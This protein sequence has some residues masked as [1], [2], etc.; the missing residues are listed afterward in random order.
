MICRGGVNGSGKAGRLRGFDGHLVATVMTRT[1][2]AVLFAVINLLIVTTIRAESPASAVR[3]G[4][5]RWDNWNL[6]SQ[7]P[8]LMDDTLR[9][10]IPYFA[11]RGSDGRLLFIGDIENVLHADIYYAKSAAINYF[12]FG[13]YMDSGAWRRDKSQ[14]QALN[15]AFQSYLNLSDRGGV[16]F[17]LSF[18]WS[19][20][21][22]DVEEVSRI[23]SGVANHPNYENAHSGL[24]PVFFFTPDLEKWY[25]GFG[26]ITGASEALASI[27][28]RVRHVTGKNIYA[29][30]FLFGINR[31]GPTAIELGFDALSTYA[32]GVGAEGKSVPYAA[33]AALARGFWESARKLPAGFLPTVTMGWDYR[34]ALKIPWS[35]PRVSLILAG[36]NLRRMLNGEGKSWRP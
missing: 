10:R 30:A 35:S 14:A 4:A 12:I 13:Y 31:F 20:P 21:N 19:F 1:Y 3:V 5:I 24:I 28:R 34:P 23:I 17:A 11:H 16:N 7:H 9:N 15:R 32:N 6:D 22:E 25:Q 26:G 36:A 29:I 8:E 27:R 33:C 2:V 18:N